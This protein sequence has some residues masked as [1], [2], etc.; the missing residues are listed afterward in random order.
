MTIG[1]A[2]ATPST[3]PVPQSTR[4]SASRVRRSVE[5]AGAERGADREL[6]FAPHGSRE[7]Q[8]R[9]VRHRDHEHEA[10]RRKK[11]EQH[12]ARLG[13]D[14]IAQPD[15]IDPEVGLR[16]VRLGMLRD[17]RRVHG[18]Q[19]GSRRIHFGAG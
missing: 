10:G 8:V 6:A 15:R 14:L 16:R 12:R 17:H 11:D 3:A 9:D 2:I 5:R 18:A 13:G 1:C 19:F 7:D 4:L